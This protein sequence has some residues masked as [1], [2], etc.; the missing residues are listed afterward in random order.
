MIHK[1]SSIKSEVIAALKE[2]GVST[3]DDVQQAEARLEGKIDSSVGKL[4]RS[5][6]RRMG[7][8]RNKILSTIG[9]LATHTP[10]ITAFRELKS[11][12]DKAISN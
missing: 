5:L 1:T 11:K 4:D 3:K 12:V 7:Q 6:K 2:I 8:D 9:S 10:T